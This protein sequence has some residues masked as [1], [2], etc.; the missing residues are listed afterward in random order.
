MPKEQVSYSIDSHCHLDTDLYPR[1]QEV[2]KEAK[3]EGVGKVIAVLSEPSHIVRYEEMVD[4]PDLYFVLGCHPHTASEYDDAFEGE[5]REWAR[6]YPEKLVGI[7][8]VGL[9][10]HYNFSPPEVQREVF[11]KQ[12]E[13]ARE[14]DLP[15]VIHTREAEEDTLN[16]LHKTGSLDDISVLFHCYS[17]SEDFLRPLLKYPHIHFSFSGIIT[18]KKSESLRQQLKAISLTNIHAETDAP[19]LA[20]VPYR[21]RENKPSYLPAIIRTMAQTLRMS[22]EVLRDILTV[23]TLRFFRIEDERIPQE[24]AYE[25]EDNIYLNIT[26]YCGLQCPFC[27]KK[28]GRFGGLPLFLKRK[29]SSGEIIRRLA[30]FPLRN[31]REIVFCGYGEPTLNLPVLLETSRWIKENTTLRVRVNTNGLGNLYN[32]K[33]IL[34]DLSEYVDYLSISLNASSSEEY[35]EIMELKPFQ[36][37]YYSHILEFLHE[38][39]K[40]FPGNSL[41]ISAV[42]LSGLDDQK[43]KELASSLGVNYRLRP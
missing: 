14:L 10:F 7:G 18:F 38:A 13:L 24:T 12:I 41:C 4:H 37:D 15:V 39:K 29:P 28:Q 31:Y 11:L 33:N 26:S 25:Y 1:W 8:E 43:F 22:P 6:K 34:P 16:L 2:L 30:E 42:R 27:I 21:G 19:Y 17:Q 36:P 20:P 32:Q 9:D 23:N 35:A 40:H 3:D 5:I